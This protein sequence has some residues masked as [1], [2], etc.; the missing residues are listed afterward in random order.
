MK[1]STELDNRLTRLQKWSE[2]YDRLL[3]REA[4][5]IE[6]LFIHAVADWEAEKK[7][8]MEEYSAQEAQIKSQLDHAGKEYAQSKYRLERD[9][10]SNKTEID[11]SG[12]PHGGG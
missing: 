12:R 4:R 7:Q 8:K 9:T 6:A 10:T 5:S 2:R 3:E 11:L 1:P